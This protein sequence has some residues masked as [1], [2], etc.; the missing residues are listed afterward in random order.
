[1][2]NIKLDNYS[3]IYSK[4]AG[5]L[6]QDITSY[7]NCELVKIVFPDITSKKIL[8]LGLGDTYVAQEMFK[9]SQNITILEGSNEIINK[10]PKYLQERTILT[11][12]EDYYPTERFDYIIATHILE[13]IEKPNILLKH[14]KKHYLTPDTK[15]LFTVPSSN[16]LHRKI[17]VELGLLS[18]P[19][20]LNTQDIQLGHQRVYSYN[21]FLNEFKSA[22]FNIKDSGG[23]FIKIV[24]HSQMKDYSR[25]LLDAIFN[26]SMKESPEICSNI[27]VTVEKND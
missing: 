7:Y 12:F 13:H 23:F 1:M 2:S 26:I 19:N 9:L 6:N 15:L 11:Y 18:K 5:K 20:D 16:S 8:L 14:I 21:E 24:S 22:D 3:E 27:W 25:E 4:E 10:A 17:G